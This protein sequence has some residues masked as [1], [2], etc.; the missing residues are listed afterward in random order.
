VLGKVFPHCQKSINL[1]NE[2]FYT[3]KKE[4]FQP[5]SQKHEQDLVDPILLPQEHH[6][7]QEIK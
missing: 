1:L 6:S 3:S 2:F 7:S 4:F 5:K